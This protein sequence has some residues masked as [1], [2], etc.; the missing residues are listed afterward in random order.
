MHNR[1]L[2]RRNRTRYHFV[3]SSYKVHMYKPSF[4]KKLGLYIQNLSRFSIGYLKVLCVSTLFTACQPISTSPI[5]S[6]VQISTNGHLIFL[7]QRPRPLL[8]QTWIYPAARN[9]GKVELAG[10]CLRLSQSASASDLIIWPPDARLQINASDVPS[11]TVFTSNN[12][13]HIGDAVIVGGGEYDPSTNLT[14]E[15]IPSECTGPF[16]LASHVTRAK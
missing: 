8:G 14:V 4:L 15:P 2:L 6:P 10:R 9:E 7:P 3:E 5:Y 12:P 1:S 16:W 11:I 13:V